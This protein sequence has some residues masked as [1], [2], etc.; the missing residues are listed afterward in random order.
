MRRAKR[1]ELGVKDDG[2]PEEQRVSAVHADVP[3]APRCV[4]RKPRIERKAI[5]DVSRTRRTVATDAVEAIAEEIAGRAH[6]SA[7]HE[8]RRVFRIEAKPLLVP[9]EKG[10]IRLQTDCR[11]PE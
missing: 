11:S 1:S 3:R 5:P 4:Q 10:R 7:E 9:N 8:H 2:W 6:P